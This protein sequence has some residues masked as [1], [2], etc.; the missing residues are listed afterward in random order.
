M[1]HILNIRDPLVPEHQP[2]IV[3][4]TP[5]GLASR[6]LTGAFQWVLSG[7]RTCIGTV[8]DGEHVPC[9]AQELVSQDLVCRACSGLEDPACVF[10]PKC[11]SNPAACT[12]LQSF[13]GVDHSVYVAFHGVLAKVGMT[14]TW[15][16][17]RRLR[18]QGAD[19]YFV[20]QSGLDR[21]GAR[22]LEDRLT[23]Q[24]GLA[25]YRTHRDTLPALARQVPRD[26]IRA[27]AVEWQERLGCGGHLTEISDHPLAQPL[28]ATPY[29]EQAHGK[30]AG[31]WVGAKGNYVIYRATPGPGRLPLD[32]PRFVAVR[33]MDLV[34]R[35]LSTDASPERGPSNPE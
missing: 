14:Q 35:W 27:R 9:P 1:D 23:M 11:R 13:H 28:P 32:R 8:H 22:D 26:A 31:T 18:E 20:V 15:R 30:H 24:H 10:E 21:P 16:L 34:G 33:R 3:V 6:S 5:H 12:C 25:Q 4:R 7:H 29:L 19:A 17:G 2:S